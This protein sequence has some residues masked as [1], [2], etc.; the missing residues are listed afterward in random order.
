MR[1]GIVSALQAGT[2][3]K[4]ESAFVELTRERAG[5]LIVLPDAF[6][7]TQARQIVELDRK[8][9]LVAMFWTREPVELE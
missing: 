2:A 5:A 8:H 7:L 9:R 6:L 1:G 3:S 4:I